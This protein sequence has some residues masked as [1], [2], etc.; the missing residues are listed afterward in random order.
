MNSSYRIHE[1][2]VLRTPRYPFSADT[3]DDAAQADKAFMES[4]YLASPVLTQEINK[5][6][7]IHDKKIL[8][9]LNKYRVR[10]A[11]RCTPFGLFSGC[12]VADWAAANTAV[13][14][15]EQQ[16]KRHTRLDMHYA[17][18]LAQHLTSLP[19][20]KNELTYFPNNS[21]YQL[22]G[23]LRYVE[24]KYE[25]GRRKHQISAV[26]HSA[27]LELI[28]KHSEQG[29][30]IAAM[31]NLIVTNDITAAEALCFIDELL[32]AQVMVSELEPAITGEEFVYQIL[33]ILNRIYTSSND[34]ELAR[35][36]ALLQEVI[37]LMDEL[38]QQQVNHPDAYVRI[39]HM[40]SQLEIPFEVNKLFQTDSIKIAETGTV[41]SSLQKDI[42]AA[43]EV[44][45]RL[46]PDPAN[47]NLDAFAARFAERYE[48]KEVP[49]LEVMDTET[50]LGYPEK[51]GNH[52]TPLIDNLLLPQPK[53]T[54][55]NIAWGPAET[56]LNEKL[57]QAH[58]NNSCTIALTDEDLE[59][60]KTANWNNLPP[61]MSVT[62][63]L[64][65][66]EQPV[67]IESVSGSSAA[68][69]LGRFAHADKAIEQL[70]ND[71]TREEEEQNPAVIFAEIIHL[72]ES[73]IGNILLHPPFRKY[74]IPYLATSS[75]E[76]DY[77]IAVADLMIAVNNNQI[78]LRSRRLNKIV[79]P[80]LST[81]HNYSLNA[82]PV[83]HFLC[84]LQHQQQRSG[85]HFTWGSLAA[86]FRFLPRVVYGNVI[87]SVAT[88]HLSKKHY[89]L[90]IDAENREDQRFQVAAFKTKWQLPCLVVLAEGDNELLINLD[91]PTSVDMFID[92][93]KQKPGIQ[94]KE[95]LKPDPHAVTDTKN[96]FYCNQ[97]IAAI[98][99]KTPAYLLSRRENTM[100]PPL[101]PQR[102]FA[103]GSA[104]VYYKCY[105]G[106]K[107]ADKILTEAVLPC[108]TAM[109]EEM[110]IDNYFFV[111]YN[112]PSF[113]IRI[114]FHL[115]QT[116]HLGKAMENMYEQLKP[117]EQQ[118]FIWKTQIDTYQREL[119]RY[120]AESI[121][122]SESLFCFDSTAVLKMLQLT[123]GDE[124]EHIRWLWTL[125]AID[126]LMNDFNFTT[127]QK[128][129]LMT[130]LKTSFL[131]EF[132]AD[133]P[134]KSQLTATYNQH[135]KKIESL[136]DHSNDS[137]SEIKPILDLIAERS[138]AVKPLATAL[139]LKAHS[140]HLS[141]P[142]GSLMSSYIH[143][144]VNRST[145]AQPRLHELVMYDML[146]RYY[147]SVKARKVDSEKKQECPIQRN[148]DA[149][150]LHTLRNP[151]QR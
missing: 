129:E 99:K 20:V 148:N 87:L 143:M 98:I 93:I 50:G 141:V 71:I 81:A 6:A 65:A 117:F 9:S 82:L 29:I 35:I 101:H 118:G 72:P 139:I 90:L 116:Q 106:A 123:G 11:T 30:T 110:L 42:T 100:L 32:E 138:D 62:F 34:P 136:L 149:G 26:F 95:F 39:Q 67:F 134:L 49:L 125:R 88:W 25:G 122:I 107:S 17:C 58:K 132:L 31:K 119:E 24:Y 91:D 27:A 127:D 83:Y 135:R 131:R 10:A 33:R 45:N 137:N 96:N 77:Q 47:T 78:V 115:T 44:L 68:N 21:L 151:F 94:L 18:A 111:R 92:A 144:L 13:R 97:F 108:I 89:R 84:D 140:N 57:N 75:A 52:T 66:G 41:N 69:L 145:L 63:R 120:G 128:L 59:A 19:C 12:N 43:L 121:E 37:V 147:F 48:N 46:H 4:L 130:H 55:G 1:K 74:E 61:S 70:V 23:E 79:V 85:L 86:R 105:C 114:R 56:M 2:L 146:Y 8:L 53:T 112:D 76:N 150:L 60:F 16:I 80:R 133:N 54:N 7:G 102:S 3:I 22:G 40:L 15:Q 104:W 38:D 109:Q 73:R 124:R 51:S 28:I 126:A 113:H 64:V 103:P 36:I 5:R 142:L 14:L